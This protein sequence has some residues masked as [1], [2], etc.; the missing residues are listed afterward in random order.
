MSFFWSFG[1]NTKKNEPS[2]P[3]PHSLPEQQQ[4][5]HKAMS[6]TFRKGV[7]YNMKIVLRGDVMTGK[8]ALFKRLQGEEFD[9][10]Y[11]STPQIQVANIPWHY[12]DSNDIIKIEVWD[13]VDKAHNN[14]NTSTESGIKL[15]HNAQP[16][17][18]QQQQQQQ[19]PS[20]ESQQLGLDASTVNVYRNTHAV[21]FLF[22]VSKQWTFDYVN[23]QLADVPEALSV[24]VIGNC[25]DKSAERVVNLDQI[26]ATLYQH[27]KE[28]IEKSAIKPN[29]IRYA[30]TSMKTGFGLKYIYDYLA[31]P[32]L[33]LQM[34]TLRKQLELKAVEIV[35]ILEALDMDEK[36]PEVMRRRRGQDNFDQPSEPHLARQ[37]EEMQNI[38]EQDVSGIAAENPSPLEIPESPSYIRK[39]TPPPPVAP[40]QGRRREG[41]L[42]SESDHMPAAV[43]QFDAGELNDDWFAS[44]D[45]PL[46]I[47]HKMP[48]NKADSDNEE[49]GGNPMVAG[50]EDVESVEY[51][52]AAKEPVV[53]TAK[54][55]QQSASESENEEDSDNDQYNSPYGDSFTATEPPS[56]FKNEFGNVWG[57]QHE[58]PSMMVVRQTRIESDSEDEDNIATTTT[59][60]GLA[61]EFHRP[62]IGTPSSFS[63]SGFG[64]Y[65]E[66]GG[67]GENPWSL[68]D[69]KRHQQEEDGSPWR[70]EPLEEEVNAHNQETEIMSE[71]RKGKKKA[72]SSSSGK[73]KSKHG[74]KKKSSTP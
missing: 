31:V 41:S 70:S 49:G 47:K 7:Q 50:D 16:K 46:A 48:F 5:A 29:L 40:V 17:Q 34:E 53:T 38:W 37:R 3:P 43:D 36:V 44:D 1:S 64:A 54:P 63:G 52:T 68:D 42:V 18:E 73:K 57:M 35:D 23:N 8:T 6:N 30:E 51:Y 9:A 39:E 15:E 13:V 72:S 55:K 2:T 32:F 25:N 20:T 10:S 33:Q 12:R 19:Q 28:R 24:L 26:H 14:K 27:N 62:D 74:K 56:L 71:K 45:T 67:D 60:P 65:E 61:Q 58:D 59:T 69:D 22:D 21:I 4:Y 11:V 66:I